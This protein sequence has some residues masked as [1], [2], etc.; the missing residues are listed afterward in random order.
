MTQSSSYI[1]SF[2]WFF[3]YALANG[4]YNNFGSIL[5]HQD[6]GFGTGQSML[7][8]MPGGGIDVVFPPFCLAGMLQIFEEPP[9]GEACNNRQCSRFCWDVFALISQPTEVP[10]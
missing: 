5:L 6:F 8:N 4:G 10:N 1:L 9:V 7:M 2:T 3:T